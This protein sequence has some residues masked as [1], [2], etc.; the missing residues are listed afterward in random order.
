MSLALLQGPVQQGYG[1]MGGP[2]SAHWQEPHL[3][4]NLSLDDC[5]ATFSLHT[6]DS[7]AVHAPTNIMWDDIMPFRE[8]QQWVSP[9]ACPQG[10]QAHSAGCD[11]HVHVQHVTLRPLAMWLSLMWLL[12]AA[13][14]TALNHLCAD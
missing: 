6:P 12:A 11:K 14:H 1:A 10:Q 3:G 2:M 7:G 4:G 8:P 13:M 5:P 9:S